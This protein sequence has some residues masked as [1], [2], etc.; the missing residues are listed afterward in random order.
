MTDAF[1]KGSSLKTIFKNL[2]QTGGKSKVSAGQNSDAVGIGS[3]LYMVP[4]KKQASTNECDED[5][6]FEP[7]FVRRFH[8]RRGRDGG[9][10]LHQDGGTRLHQNYTWRDSE[11]TISKPTLSMV[12]TRGWSCNTKSKMLT[13]ERPNFQ[14]LKRCSTFFQEK[15]MNKTLKISKQVKTSN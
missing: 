3:L 1:K 5:I 8:V 7:T 10:R 14:I 4:R 2:H 12:I 6:I 9:P 11:V 13:M 15:K